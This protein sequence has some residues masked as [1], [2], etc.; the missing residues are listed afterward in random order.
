MLSQ[1]VQIGWEEEE[2]W[3][4][5]RIGLCEIE[6]RCNVD[7]HYPIIYIRRVFILFCAHPVIG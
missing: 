3:L 4:H 6:T 7:L 5:E 2:W 1:T